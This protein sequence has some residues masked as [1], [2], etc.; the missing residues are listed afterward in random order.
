V[1]NFDEIDRARRLLDLGE[2][3]T[4]KDIKQAIGRRL[5]SITPTLQKR[6]NKVRKR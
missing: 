6:S 2:A 5:F 4:L 1:A 3:A